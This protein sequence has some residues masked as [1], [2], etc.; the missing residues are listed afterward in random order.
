MVGTYFGSCTVSTN[1]GLQGAVVDTL[2]IEKIE[3]TTYKIRL[4]HSYW[5]QEIQLD[6]YGQMV[7]AGTSGGVQEFW[8][9]NNVIYVDLYFSGLSM[10][11]VRHVFHGAK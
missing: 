8:L 1:S 6:A 11:W 3:N 7:A 4:K 2:T 9:S 10:Q 5:N